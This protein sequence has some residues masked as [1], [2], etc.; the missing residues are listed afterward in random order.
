MTARKTSAKLT[1]SKGSSLQKHAAVA[2]TRAAEGVVDVRSGKDR[3]ATSTDRRG[4][5]IPV[6]VER[7]QT[8]R[9][10]KVNRRRQIDPT[11]CERDYTVEEIEFMSALDAYKRASGRMF[12]TC[13]EVLEVIRKL[14]YQR[15]PVISVSLESPDVSMTPV[16]L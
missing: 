16:S 13:S 5:E 15:Q 12:P 6:A 7:R 2:E 14:G 11:T 8:E 3:R 1:K 9:R 10:V 4:K